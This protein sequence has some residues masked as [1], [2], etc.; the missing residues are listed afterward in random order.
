MASKKD[1]RTHVLAV[2]FRE[3]IDDLDWVE[4]RIDVDLLQL[5]DENDRR[6]A[7][8]RNRGRL[9]LEAGAGEHAQ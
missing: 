2:D 8:G 9:A 1:E 6:V 5:V 3:P 7:I 4:H